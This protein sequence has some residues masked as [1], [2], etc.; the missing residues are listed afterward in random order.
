VLP[1]RCQPGF[2]PFSERPLHAVTELSPELSLNA[3]FRGR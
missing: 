2:Q 1:A 3:A